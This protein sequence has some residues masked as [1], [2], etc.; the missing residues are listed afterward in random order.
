VNPL[1]LLS[2]GLGGGYLGYKAVTKKSA[3]TKDSYQTMS[4]VAPNGAVVKVATPVASA[5]TVSQATAKIA[6]PP[7]TGQYFPVPTTVPGQ[8]VTYAP[9][10]TI[11]VTKNGVVAQPA[12]III[13][14]SGASSLAIGSVKDVQR[15]LNTL[16]YTKPPLKEDGIIGPKTVAAIRAF[17]GKNKLVIDGSA[18]PAVKAALSASLSNTAG[19]GSV[20]GSITQRSSPET[21]A[22]VAPSG[23][24]INTKA[25]LAMTTRDVQYSLNGLGASPKL[26]VDGKLGPK[27][28]AAIKCFQA[29]HGLITDGVAGAKT[30][31]VLYQ[32]Y[33]PTPA[34]VTR[35]AGT[36]P[37]V[38]SGPAG[39]GIPWVLRP[40]PP[41]P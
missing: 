17:Q 3:L 26:V 4:S 30:K 7:R 20:V 12:P 37:P 21:G 9:P 32:L 40:M 25:A 16:G 33:P 1:F 22:I 23:A 39:P 8:G 28:V 11:Q 6:R 35:P 29:A 38:S 14:K 36:K 27:T 19:G 18:G 13:T 15:A 41:T 24:V 5:I 31:T 2:L 10:G 34:G